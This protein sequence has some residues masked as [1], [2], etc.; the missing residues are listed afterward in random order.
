[1]TILL[2]SITDVFTLILELLMSFLVIYRFIKFE[3]SKKSRQSI[4]NQLIQF[5]LSNNSNQNNSAMENLRRREELA[6]KKLLR[7]TISMSVPSFAIHLLLAIRFSFLSLSNSNK[8]VF[9]F[10]S[11]TRCLTL[12]FIAI[13]SFFNFFV[14]YYFNSKFQSQF[15][16]M[17]SFNKT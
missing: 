2:A 9:F 3:V 17:F 5:G 12:F 13:K 16:K 7:M 8:D 1:M 14:F 10:Y 11:L 6:K 4:T 15:K